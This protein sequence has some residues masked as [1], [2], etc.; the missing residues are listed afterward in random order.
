MNVKHKKNT[1]QKLVNMYENIRYIFSDSFQIVKS[2]GYDE[3]IDCRTVFYKIACQTTQ[4]NVILFHLIDEYFEDIELWKFQKLENEEQ[5]QQFLRNQLDLIISDLRENLFVN[6]FLRFENFIKLISRSQEINGNKLNKLSKDLIDKLNLNSDYKN[7]I[8]LITYIRNTIHTEGF[9]TE[10]DITILYNSQKFEL[11]QKQPV[12]FYNE[13]FLYFLISEINKFI[14][15]IINSNDIKSI[16]K[17]E[18]TYVGL[19]HIYE[20]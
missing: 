18:H 12:T 11:K 9:H 15:E 8:N 3:N 13:D 14:L 6:I 1:V 20:E 2:Y 17:I 16:P 5:K 10:P 4:T 19:N 7:L